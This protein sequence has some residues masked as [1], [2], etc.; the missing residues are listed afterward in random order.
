[1]KSERGRYLVTALVLLLGVALI[2]AAAF[3]LWANDAAQPM[4]E[5]L[6]ALKTDEFVTFQ[7]KNGWLVFAPVSQGD[8]LGKPL[9]KGL[10][11]YPGGKVDYRAYAPIARAIAEKG[12][13]VVVPPM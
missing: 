2:G 12:Y 9:D 4:P 11:I 5:A 10:I 1:M 8:A 13:L 7:N 6:A 3:V